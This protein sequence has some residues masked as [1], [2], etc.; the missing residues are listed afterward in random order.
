[1]GRLIDADALLSE[2]EKYS[3]PT[4]MSRNDYLFG[5]Q[6]RLETCIELVEDAPTVDAV[7]VR[8]GRWI[9][10]ERD[11]LDHETDD[12]RVFRT[13]KWWKCSECGNAKGYI[14]HKPSDNFCSKCGADMRKDGDADGV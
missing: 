14:G 9:Y 10:E 3:D 8:R 1:M 13:E 11:R 2:L 5:M 6:Q 4:A 12:G 7:P